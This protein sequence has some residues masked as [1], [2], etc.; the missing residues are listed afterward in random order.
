MLRHF[1]YKGHSNKH[2][3]L[4][5][6]KFSPLTFD[7]FLHDESEH[8]INVILKRDVLAKTN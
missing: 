7:F 2:N 6:L 5:Q 1:F 4:Y 8:S 3:F